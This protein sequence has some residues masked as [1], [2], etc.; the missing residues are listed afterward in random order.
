MAACYITVFLKRIFFELVFRGNLETSQKTMIEK[1][2]LL[3][4][5][6]VTSGHGYYIRRAERGR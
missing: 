3:K 2:P 1:Y 4:D 5:S 6:N